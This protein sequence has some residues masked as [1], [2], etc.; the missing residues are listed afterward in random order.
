MQ[1]VRRALLRADKLKQPIDGNNAPSGVNTSSTITC[2]HCGLPVAKEVDLAVNIAGKRRPMCCYGCQ[3]VAQTIVNNAL[4]DY[5]LN[6]DAMPDSP[7]EAKPDFLEQLGLFDHTEFQKGFVRQ[8]ADHEREASLLFEGVNCAACTWLIEESAARLPGVVAISVNYANHRARLRWNEKRI[9]LSEILQA[10]ANI[11]YRAYPY[12]ASRHEELAQKERRAALWRV[13]VAG[14]GMMQVMMYAIPGY[15]AGEGEMTPE[16]W[17]LL[18]WASLLLTLP[19][20]FYSAAPFFRFAWRDLRLRRVGIDVPVALGIGTAFTASVWATLTQ[21]GEIYFDSVAMFVF[22]LQGGRYLEMNARQKAASIGE[23][24]GRLQPVFAL[25][26]PDYPHSMREQQAASS[27]LQNGDT[28]LVRPGEVIPADGKIIS[29]ESSVNE[30]LITGESQPVARKAGERVVG[31]A[32]NGEGPLVMTVQACGDN[33]WLSTIVRLMERAALEKPSIVH[34]ADLVARYFIVAV[35]LIAAATALVWWQID[36]DK[37]LWV[38]VSVLVVTCPCALSLATP[39]ALTVTAG[40]LARHGLVATRAHAIET[41]SRA[42]HFIFDKTGTLTSGH[43][44]LLDILP[45]S[46]QVGAGQALQLAAA[47]EQHSEHPLARAICEA[48]ACGDVSA[49]NVSVK[50]EPGLPLVSDCRNLPGQGFIG[51]IAG[52]YY[53]IGRLPST[54]N[55]WQQLPSAW[56]ESTDS[57]VALLRQDELAYPETK[58]TGWEA[59]ALFRLGDEVRAGAKALVEQLQQRN[60]LVQLLSGDRL[61]VASRVANQLGIRHVNGDMTPQAKQEH[62]SS[63]EAKGAVVAMIGD[64]VNDAPVLAQAQVSIAM[65]GGTS[66]AHSQADLLLISDNLGHLAQGLHIADR[67]MTIVRQ[68]LLWAALY[69]IMVLPLAVLGF[70]TPWMAG[71]GMSGSSLLVVLNALRIARQPMR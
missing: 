1:G 12:D 53:R 58:A 35:L 3:M 48:A 37:L 55:Q 25:R 39:T 52:H 38:T 32:T 31:G 42:T 49:Q 6:R 24:L 50:S 28:L 63:L 16:I 21:S 30:S 17:L 7:R 5:Y 27:E 18:R 70:I 46:A 51:R 43:M 71:I 33:T 59:L 8:L 29:G 34:L 36:S 26:L 67:C 4:Q 40:V 9:K 57:V 54:Y 61:Q 66:L 14:F 69:N 62:V 20:V 68:N 41:L 11:G 65:G 45:L 2:Y 60:K 22:L 15:L 10:I 56:H 44:R 47:L 64:G 19:V 23:A 13:W